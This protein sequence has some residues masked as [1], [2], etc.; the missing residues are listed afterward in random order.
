MWFDASV[1]AGIPGEWPLALQPVSLEQNNGSWKVELRFFLRTGAGLINGQIRD[2]PAPLISHSCENHA[3]RSRLHRV[4]GPLAKVRSLS[5]PFQSRSRNRA[6]IWPSLCRA[7]C[8]SRGSS[9]IMWVDSSDLCSHC[10]SFIHGSARDPVSWCLRKL[11]T[12]TSYIFVKSVN[13]QTERPTALW[14]PSSGY[15]DKSRSAGAQL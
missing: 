15:S 10:S 9:Q 1:T 4:R 8:L 3:T 2:T 13:P 11:Q 12:L 7:D 14:P 5:R 6:D